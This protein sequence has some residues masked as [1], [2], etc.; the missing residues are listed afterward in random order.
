MTVSWALTSCGVIAVVLVLRAAL[1]RWISARLRYALWLLAL[2][3]LLIPAQLITVPAA[4]LS[5]P[6]MDGR[7][8][9][10]E[11]YAIPT[12]RVEGIPQRDVDIM[13]ETFQPGDVFTYTYTE[14]NFYD[15]FSFSYNT[16]CGVIEKDG[17]Y[18]YA[19][20]G[21]LRQVLSGIYVIGVLLLLLVLLL[22]NFRFARRLRRV[23]WPVD[24]A[25]SRLPVYGAIGLPSPCLFGLFRPAIYLTPE[26]AGD[27]AVRRHVLVHE[28]T[29]FRH[30]D[31]IWSLLRCLALALHWWNP[32]V[33]LGAVLSRRDGELA[34]DEG[35]LRRLGDGQ[36]AAYGETLLQLV[37]VKAGPRDL[38]SSATT[39][40]GGKRELRERIRLISRKRKVLVSL[41]AAAVLLL[42][43]LT[44]VAFL[45]PEDESWRTAEIMVDE[46]GIPY[47]RDAGEWEWT[48]LG[49]PIAPPAEWAE[50]D[51]AGR[52]HAQAL[53]VSDSAETYAGYVS[54]SGAWLAVT[55]GRGVAA[56][57]TYVYRSEDGGETW[58]EVAKP[59]TSWNLSAVGFLNE[60]AMIVASR[61]FDGAPVYITRDGGETW[62]EIP[63]PEGAYQ[64]ESVAY[65][66]ET[67]SIYVSASATFAY[68]DPGWVL[69][70]TDLGATWS[71]EKADAPAV[72]VLPEYQ[73]DLGPVPQ[74]VMADVTHDGTPDEL[75]VYKETDQVWRLSVTDGATG[76]RIW[77]EEAGTPHAGWN[78]L[79]LCALEGEGYIL[80]YNPTM[81]QG[82]CD[83]SYQVFWLE[84]GGTVIRDQSSVHFTID[85]PQE[86]TQEMTFD[87]D[88]IAAFLDEVNA[89]LAQSQ[90]LLVTDEDLLNTFAGQE[91]YLMDTLWWLDSDV[92]VRN[93]EY[94][95]V[96]NLLAY[97]KAVLSQAPIPTVAEVF[98]SITAEAIVSIEPRLDILP[99]AL[100]EALNGAAET[101]PYGLDP[102]MFTSN[103]SVTVTY[104]SEGDPGEQTMILETGDTEDLVQVTLSGQSDHRF[105]S[106]NREYYFRYEDI[107]YS[108]T[109]LLMDKT[110]YRTVRGGSQAAE[111]YDR[112][113]AGEITATV[114]APDGR[115]WTY[116]IA[117]GTIRD[118]GD[119]LDGG[120]RWSEAE[121]GDWE[122]QGGDQVTLAG[123]SGGLSL[124]ARSG[125]DVVQL[126][127]GEAVAYLRAEDKYD[128]SDDQ[129]SMIFRTLR[130]PLE[131]I[132]D[133]A[134][135]DNAVVDGSVTDLEAVARQMTEQIAKGYRDLPDFLVWKPNDVQI[136]EAP[137][138]V[139]DAWYGEEPNF[140]FGMGIYISLT[141]P[142]SDQ[143]SYWQP[144]A[145]LP[146]EP[147]FEDYYP[148]GMEVHAV[149][150]QEADLWRI[151][152]R[153]TGGYSV[154]LPFDIA[155]AP[156]SELVDAWFLSGGSTHDYLLLSYLCDRPL[157]DLAGLN[158]ALDQRSG[159]EAEAF[160]LG[161]KLHMEE[162]PSYHDL[163]I[164]D[165]ASALDAPYAAILS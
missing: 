21:N 34:C 64:A 116:A 73:D 118:P 71:T 152:G 25:G 120:Y 28:E 33:W 26:A 27:E 114:E 140:C 11:L 75:T 96:E 99:E 112:I 137:Q 148:W 84:N 66:G 55:Y 9:E 65:D 142:L 129:E 40:T 14:K 13:L 49:G 132:I 2:V 163:T 98:S 111:V 133:Q 136:Q 45:G 18:T 105:V 54:A 102:D 22:S 123:Q 164:A 153:G 16:G 108:H 101:P 156:V 3:R 15:M 53:E 165:I 78:A 144:G 125:G 24:D 7:L 36:R 128:S 44:V 31:H 87:P 92:Y 41:S 74:T 72:A 63:L 4:E 76:E 160:L 149:L 161:L 124:S 158:D 143:G 17:V 81:Y 51:L 104:L 48:Q 59:P 80:R 47:R 95:L 37:T 162:F 82:V 122:T 110:L 150:D 67:V 20:Y 69:R 29:H 62:E 147:V 130:L 106:E 93:E 46:S 86:T 12:G 117:P 32:L 57:D 10:I 50:Q 61:L 79:F 5:L 131:S 30:G 70:S 91:G 113:A 126:R 121:E 146:E 138:R 107:P 151:E 157:S 39:M 115:R 35:A 154:T 58:R 139:F 77:S 155:A 52:D 90:I 94:T 38:L 68:W 85:P 1:G 134:V 60:D 119:T 145:G 103:H 100:A 89:Y 141:D 8:E 127:T 97:W 109:S 19:L 43:L 159:E 135:W 42:S 83:Y 23:R 56:A 6:D 88:A